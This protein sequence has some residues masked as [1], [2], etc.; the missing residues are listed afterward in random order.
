VQVCR[1]YLNVELFADIGTLHPLAERMLLVLVNPF[2][3]PGKALHIF[4][5]HVVPL[6]ADAGIRYQLTVTGLISIC[7]DIFWQKLTEL[8]LLHKSSTV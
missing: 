8:E 2:S 5:R 7:F 1:C 4:Q 6:F 3:G